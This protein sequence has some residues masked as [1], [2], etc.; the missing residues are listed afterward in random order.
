M[1]HFRMDGADAESRFRALCEA[2]ERYVR[3]LEA[4]WVAS[5]RNRAHSEQ[6]AAM[7]DNMVGGQL[8]D[9]Q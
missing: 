9:A 5:D 3:F 8:A 6:V 2:R 7:R 4:E 1:Q